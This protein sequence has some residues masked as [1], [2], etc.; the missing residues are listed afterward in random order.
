MA[1]YRTQQR[2]IPRPATMECQGIMVHPDF[3][4]DT[5]LVLE[6]DG[7]FVVSVE[8]VHG[9]DLVMI[10]YLVPKASEQSA[11]PSAPFPSRFY[12]RQ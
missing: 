5:R 2:A 10:M 1:G 11:P 8:P 3:A 6:R 4:D 9:A 7:G 12:G